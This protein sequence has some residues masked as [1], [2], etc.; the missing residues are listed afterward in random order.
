[1]MLKRDPWSHGRPARLAGWDY[2]ADGHYFITLVAEKRR[3]VFGTVVFD[4][5]RLTRIGE[6]VRAALEDTPRRRQGV[7]L[8]TWVIMPDHLHALLILQR[9]GRALDVT[10]PRALHRP[11]NSL[12][13]LVAQFKSKTTHAVRGVAD[14]PAGRLWQRG[15]FER[16]VRNDEELHAFRRYIVE[17]PSR[18]SR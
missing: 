5:V 4:S 14:A 2:A 6:I 10:I 9:S 1:M 15:F 17:N 3:P 11:G 16:V 18:A 13:S 12:S 7:T 8:D